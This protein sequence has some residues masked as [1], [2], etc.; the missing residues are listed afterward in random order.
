MK[1]LLEYRVFDLLKDK[2]NVDFLD[3]V[4]KET[5]DQYTRFLN[6]VGN[7]GLEKAK[8]MYQEFDP[9]YIKLQKQ[10]EKEDK[11]RRKKESTKEYKAWYKQEVLDMHKQQI[12]DIESVLLNSPLKVLELRIKKD[13]RISEYLESCKAKKVYENKFKDFLKNPNQYYELNSGKINIGTLIFKATWL[14]YAEEKDESLNI[15]KV[16]HYYDHNKKE[17]TYSVYLKLFDNEYDYF[18]PKLDG[19]KDP[20]FL[21]QRSDY[22]E[23]IGKS[24]IDE[25]ELYHII[26]KSF[27]N[28]L[29]EDVYSRWKME[30]DAKKYNL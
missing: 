12:E 22:V 25:H 15:I 27:S 29:R 5:P 18:L 13:P 7:K 30:K 11:L 26:F 24:N 16:S 2:D 1:K 8:E 3:K 23:K 4:K 20:D 10:K 17:S 21:R 28:I 14:N 19:D 6:L 9:E